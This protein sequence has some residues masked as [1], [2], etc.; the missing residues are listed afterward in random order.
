VLSISD[1]EAALTRIRSSI[2]VTPCEPSE[3]FSALTGNHVFFKLENLLM[4]GSFKERGAL[5]KLLLLTA[6]E[7]QRGVICA[8][9]GNHAQG[10]AYHAT[11]L[12]IRAQVVM[13]VFAPLNK[14]TATRGYGAE[15][16]LHGRSFDEALEEAQRRCKAEHLTFVHAFDDDAV[17][18]GQGT[19]GIELLQQNPFLEVVI[20]P[21]GGG[22]LIGGVACA[23]KETNP[24]IRVIGVQTARIPSMKAA[25]EK[26]APV[27]LPAATTIADG[28][29]VRCAGKHTLPLVQKYVDEVVTVEEEEIASAILAMLEKEK[30]V[31]EGAGAAG[32]AALLNGHTPM[33]NR[34]VAVIVC[35]GNIDAMFLSRIIER[36]MV[37]DGRLV[38]LRIHVP[39]RPGAIHS[40]TGLL[41]E[42]QVNVVSIEHDRAYH[43]VS[44]GET[45]VEITLETRGASHVDE[46][47][48]SIE[49][50]HYKFERIR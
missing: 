5:N 19:I 27:V 18:A 47:L 12:G 20:V 26:G 8:S 22:G 44:L 39:D 29:A 38:R 17:I 25:L 43:G 33:K 13:P 4:S 45:A 41:A 37:K 14:I 10:V 21:I 49:S 11:R 6:K 32:V 2:A 50:A 15:V 36:G 28:I 3:T 30:T 34:K 42:A 23:L 1:I 40:L 35:G 9:A 24:R 46:L 48:K 16:I 7:R 31:C